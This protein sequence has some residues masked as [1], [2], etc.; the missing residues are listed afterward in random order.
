MKV[1]L[2]QSAV[3]SIKAHA[4]ECYP[5]ECCG[6][7]I[8]GDDGTI[9]AVAIRN[10]QD[11]MHE[12]D[13]KRYPRTA[14]T[15]YVAEPGELRRALERGEAPGKKVVAFYHSHPDHDAYFSDEDLAQATPFG[16][17]SYPEALQIVVSIRDGVCEDFKVFAW[18]QA[19]AA[20]READ[21][22]D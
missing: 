10:V 20:Y 16:E 19:D 18:S 1:I 15:A 22:E 8:R 4:G 9:E 3:D 7:V 17:P 13:P 6:L 11:E 14:R 12:Q 21:L 5:D 2:E